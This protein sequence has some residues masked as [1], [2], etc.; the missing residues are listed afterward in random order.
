MVRNLFRSVVLTV[1]L[2]LGCGLVYPV[3]G[4]ALTQLAFHAQANG[5]VSANGSALIGQPWNNGTSINPR[6]FNG[7]P[8]ADNPL[9][10]NGTVGAS[11]ATNLGPRSKVLVTSVR[12]LIGEWREV[13]VLH[14]TPDLVTSSGSGLDPDISLAD[15]M[16]Q[17]PMIARARHVAPASLRALVMSHVRGA[18]FG[19]L[20]Q[21]TINVLEL[22]EALAKLA[23]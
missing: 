17:V 13:G 14:P 2:A 8:D 12:R 3:A 10:L 5:S 20:G 21:A 22:N 11:G 1:V 6:W 18:Q 7:R 9:E 16:V 4:W 19:F 23:P 15:A